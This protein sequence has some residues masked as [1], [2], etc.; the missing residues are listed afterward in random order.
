LATDPSENLNLTRPSFLVDGLGDRT[1]VGNYV[2]DHY[3]SNSEEDLYRGEYQIISTSIKGPPV[4][5]LY[6]D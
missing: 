5:D 4:I 1:A 2:D 3:G 6:V